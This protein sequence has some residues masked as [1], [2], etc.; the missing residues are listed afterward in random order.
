M[1]F[2]NN[3]TIDLY[4]HCQDCIK[5]LPEDLSPQEN[6]HMEAGVIYDEETNTSMI[7]FNCVRHEL[8]IGTMPLAYNPLEDAS[9]DCEGC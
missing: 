4:I 7:V 3:D 1:D 6:I 2:F 5:D 8:T 9:C